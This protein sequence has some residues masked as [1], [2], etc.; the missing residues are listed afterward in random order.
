MD[1][2]VVNFE[3]FKEKKEKIE[4]QEAKID[5]E[6]LDIMTDEQIIASITDEKALARFRLNCF[7]EFLSQISAL[8]KQVE[9]LSQIISIASAD[10]LTN[11]FKEL[12]KNVNAEENRIEL[13]EKIKKS[14][15]KSTK[16]AKKPKKA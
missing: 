15:K 14:H 6:V 12:N 2:K 5:K 3:E 9:E 16:N 8:K 13:Q 4:V 1:K 7:C 11:F 10:K